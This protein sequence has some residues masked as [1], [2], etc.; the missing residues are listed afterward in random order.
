[1]VAPHLKPAGQPQPAAYLAYYNLLGFVIELYLKAYLREKTGA[2]VSVYGHDLKALF[3]EA[4][5]EGFAYQAAGM[6]DIVQAIADGHKGLAFR[7]AEQTSTY[8]HI[9][10]LDL[11]AQ[12]LDASRDGMKHLA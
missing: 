1:M 7:Y 11:V 3:T 4:E 2:D 12:V 6:N 5:K 8:N 10:Q 9:N